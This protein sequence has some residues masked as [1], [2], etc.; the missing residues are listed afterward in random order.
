MEMKI[1][2]LCS[3]DEMDS[4][5]GSITNTTVIAAVFV[6][7]SQPAK[8]T[9]LRGISLRLFRALRFYIH[10]RKTETTKNLSVVFTFVLFVNLNNESSLI[11]ISMNRFLDLDPRARLIMHQ[12]DLNKKIFERVYRMLPAC[13]RLKSKAITEQVECRFTG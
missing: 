11:A 2:T 8:L 13:R 5:F 7:E 3:F 6:G 4:A 12:Y 9:F 1:A 10:R